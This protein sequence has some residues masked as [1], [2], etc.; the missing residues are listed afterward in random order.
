[1]EFL[2][3]SKSLFNSSYGVIAVI[4]AIL[5][6]LIKA[7]TMLGQAFDFHDKNIIR[8]RLERLER[9]RS[10]I[11]DDRP[12]AEYFDRAIESEKFRISSG[13]LASHA[14]MNVLI[15]IDNIGLWERQ[16]IKSIAKYLKTD[17]KTKNISLQ[18]TKLDKLGATISIAGGLA[19]LSIGAMYLTLLTFTLKPYGIMV[20][21]LTF[22]PFVLAGRLFSA[23]FISYRIAKKVKAHLAQTTQSFP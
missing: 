8:K 19:L 6:S 15:T 12:L 16:Q 9:L 7:L 18:L 10:G 5:A 20:G 22:L 2:E 14:K 4:I 11:P 3:I 23:D 17:Q 1:M 13:I 21:A